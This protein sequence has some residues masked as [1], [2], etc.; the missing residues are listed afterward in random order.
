LPFEHIA[1][2]AGKLV[3]HRVPLQDSIAAGDRRDGAPSRDKVAQR[4]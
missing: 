2:T 4:M 3:R 1:P